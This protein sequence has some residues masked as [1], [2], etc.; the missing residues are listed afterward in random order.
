MKIILKIAIII[1][2]LLFLIFKINFICDTDKVSITAHRGDSLNYNENTMSA[3]KSAIELGADYIELDVRKTKDN[4]IVIAHD[5]SLKRI[6]KINKKISNLTYDE[7]LKLD[8]RDDKIPLLEDAIVLAKEN[9]IKLNIELKELIIEKNLVNDVIDLLNKY[10]YT[11]NVVLSSFKYSYLKKAK[12]INPKI[13]TIYNMS[14]IDIDA[15]EYDVDGFSV[16][17][18][19]ITEG[20]I[21][22]AHDKQKEVCV[23]TINTEDEVKKMLDYKVDNII[24]DDVKL[25]KKF[26][27]N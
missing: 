25:V 15:L 24:A 16:N 20:F 13:K 12:E 22:K 18:Y 3:F 27:K 10:H 4:K 2:V 5:N 19:L 8:N 21:K 6:L 26:A 23:W 9:R 7:I 1:N 11:D 17:K 14:L